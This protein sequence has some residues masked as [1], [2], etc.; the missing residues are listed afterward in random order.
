M[1]NV[2]IDDR[3]KKIHKKA[4]SERKEFNLKQVMAE[5]DKFFVISKERN[6]YRLILSKMEEPL[7]KNVLNE[8]GGN[9]RKAAQILGINRN[10]LYVKIKRLGI[11][12]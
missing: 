4:G 2:K 12:H 8:T 6:L 5:L 11:G 1:N 10:T 9:K 7:I 3:L